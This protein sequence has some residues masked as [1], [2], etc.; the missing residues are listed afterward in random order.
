M[1]SAALLIFSEAVGAIG[2]LFLP[3]LGGRSISTSAWVKTAVKGRFAAGMTVSSPI[4]C[5]SKKQPVLAF[6]VDFG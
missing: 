6:H 4:G 3:V 2:R 1:Q 5:Y